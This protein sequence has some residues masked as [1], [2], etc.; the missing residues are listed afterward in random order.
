M[1]SK[2]NNMSLEQ[3]EKAKMLISMTADLTKEEKSYYYDLIEAREA[4]LIKDTNVATSEITSF[5]IGWVL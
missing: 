5:E 1:E 4:T 2:I 3:L